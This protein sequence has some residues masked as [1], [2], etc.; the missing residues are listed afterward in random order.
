MAQRLEA[1]R[2]RK[3]RQANQQ[4]E[5]GLD[6]PKHAEASRGSRVA[7]AVAA[8]YANAPSY[9][10]LLAA[11][12][13]AALQQAKVAAAAAHAA[14]ISAEASA[15]AHQALLA[16]FEEFEASAESREQHRPLPIKHARTNRS[17]AQPHGDGPP[18]PAAIPELLLIQ[19]REPATFGDPESRPQRGLSVASRG[20][21]LEAI[22]AEQPGYFE[23][24]SDEWLQEHVEIFAGPAHEVVSLPANLIEF[25]RQLV[26]P[27]KARP[28]LAEGPLREDSD[29]APENAQLRIFE[30]EAAIISNRA[31]EAVLHSIV[32]WSS[33]RLDTPAS[34]L[35]PMYEAEQP[36]AHANLA[37]YLRQS[38]QTAPLRMRLMAAAVDFCLICLAFLAFASAFAATTTHLPPLT[39]ALAG[40]GGVF[41][42]IVLSYLFLFFS[43]A[44]ATPGMRYARIGLCT[45]EDENPTRS[46]LRRRIVAML[47]SACPLGLGFAWACFDDDGLCWHDR[48][49]RM[50]QRS[51]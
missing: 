41:F 35:L 36:L 34:A 11:Q 19:G 50:Y 23:A 2:S 30:V 16:G 42:A 43:L 22:S 12:A 3:Q 33:I 26:A 31:P 29:A 14:A 38:P 21:S 20:V 5:L 37:P 13:E 47:L 32:E 49:S 17:L 6:L 18:D 7:A 9:R 28:R 51:Y 10:D 27:R 4:P 25:P 48:I 24:E 39:I 44:E 15:V 46:A 45:F 8:R 40:G 1:H